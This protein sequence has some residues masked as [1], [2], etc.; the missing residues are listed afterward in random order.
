MEWC[1][2][3]NQVAVIVLQNYGKSYSQI[4]RTL[5][6]IDNFAIVHL[7]G[8]SVLRNFGGLKTGLSQ[9]A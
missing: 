1:V 7:S 2:K 5:K 9:D 6:T 4:F 8:N 3:E